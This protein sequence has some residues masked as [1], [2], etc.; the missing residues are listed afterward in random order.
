MLRRRIMDQPGAHD[1]ANELSQQPSPSESTISRRQMKKNDPAKYKAY[2]EK[3]KERNRERRKHLKTLKR[4]TFITEEDK[5]V[6]QN[7][8]QKARLRQQRYRQRLKERKLFHG[9]TNDKQKVKHAP[10]LPVASGTRGQ[11]KDERDRLALQREKWRRDK[12]NQRMQLK[13]NKKKLTWSKKKDRARRKKKRQEKKKE[14]KHH[15]PLAQIQLGDAFGNKKTLQNRTCITRNT[16]PNTPAKFA[17]VFVQ[18]EHTVTPRKRKALRNVR[19]KGKRRRIDMD[20][21]KRTSATCHPQIKKCSTTTRAARKVLKKM[22]RNT[23]RRKNPAKS[24]SFTV[25]AFYFKVATPLPNKRYATKHGPGYIMG[26][27]LQSA[28]Q[29]F[30]KEH[31][32]V[33]VGFTKFTT[34]RPRNVR[35]LSK[36]TWIHSLCTVCQNITYKLIVLNKQTTTLARTDLK[37]HDIAKLIDVV[38]CPKSDGQRY[39]TEKC[40]YQTCN[41][42]SNQAVARLQDHYKP[43]L[44]SSKPSLSWHHW[45]KKEVQNKKKLTV[46]TKTGTVADLLDE[47]SKDVNE[48]VQKTSLAQHNFTASWQSRMYHHCKQT[49]EPETVLMVV[50]FGKNRALRHQDEAKAAGFGYTQV[51]IHPIV[52][53]YHSNGLLVRDSMIILSEDITHDHLAVEYFMKSA[54]E[55]LQGNVYFKKIIAWSDGCCSQYKCKGSL[56]AMSLQQVSLEWNYFGSEHGKGEADGEI[57]VLNR[58][59]DL[60]VKGRKVIINNAL[61]MYNYCCSS[62]LSYD[63]PTSK[64]HF[65]LAEEIPREKNHTNVELVQG[66][67]KMHQVHTSGKEY[68]VDIRK[69]SCYCSACCN[70]AFHKCVNVEY[71]GKM[72]RKKLVLL[73]PEKQLKGKEI[74]KPPVQSTGAQ[75]ASKE[76]SQRKTSQ[77]EHSTDKVRTRLRS[78]NNEKRICHCQNRRF[79]SRARG[80]RV[81]QRRVENNLR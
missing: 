69:L 73:E 45:E 77:E 80:D 59:L 72:N 6:L 7:D 18:L 70:K 78:R 65:V 11:I 48:P 74:K 61:E 13:E 54:V 33:K 55:Y 39:H 76:I 51:T 43:L 50:D 28:Y 22:S 37:I 19:L 67:R 25:K 57:G 68:E 24:V 30:K 34:L 42:C 3:Q 53:Y 46:I 23:A 29:L 8:A 9:E 52:M 20:D 63:E 75:R 1:K 56:A 27:S 49:L 79:F 4:K 5:Q 15:V 14:K 40:I 32:D 21:D 41:T 2:L 62:D 60:A 47:M 10:K 35:L 17:Q 81:N 31:S 26:I 44:E 12:Q 66:I 16:M 71:V 58:A 36:S 64:R 38:L